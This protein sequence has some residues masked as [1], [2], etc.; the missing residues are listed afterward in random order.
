MKRM[1]LTALLFAAGFAAPAAALAVL[2]SQS[3]KWAL[4]GAR[5]SDRGAS[6]AFG[7]ADLEAFCFFP[8][9][10]KYGATILRAGTHFFALNGNGRTHAAGATVTWRGAKYRVHDEGFGTDR[11]E[12]LG[13]LVMP[14]NAACQQ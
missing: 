5:I 8:A 4:S 11:A 7:T 6:R 14:G 13:S 1:A 2:E 3:G 12:A 10:P 9:N